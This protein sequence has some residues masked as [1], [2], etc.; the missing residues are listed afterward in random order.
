MPGE[1]VVPVGVKPYSSLPNSY[2]IAYACSKR[3][4]SRHRVARF[5]PGPRI[6]DHGGAGGFARWSIREGVWVRLPRAAVL[7]LRPRRGGRHGRGHGYDNARAGN[8]GRVQNVDDGAGSVVKAEPAGELFALVICEVALMAK[9]E[10][11]SVRCELEWEGLDKPRSSVLLL[12]SDVL[13][14]L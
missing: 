3:S 11:G 8:C 4:L 5:R 7:S 13:G 6:V 10:F 2:R 9:S 1:E 14:F 12:L